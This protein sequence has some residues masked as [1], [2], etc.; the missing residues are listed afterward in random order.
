MHKKSKKVPSLREFNIILSNLSHEDNIGH[1][2]IV[3]IKYHDKNPKIMLFNE[4]YTPIF[5]KQKD[6]KVH[7]HSVLQLMSVLSRERG[8]RY[9]Q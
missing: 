5:D 9:Y 4:I 6:V 7:E 3:D 2:F 8:Q 1:S